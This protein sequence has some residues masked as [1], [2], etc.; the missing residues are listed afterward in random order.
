MTY[1]AESVLTI[2]Q[3]AKWLQCSTRMVERKGLRAIYLGPRTRRYLGST[4]LEYLKKLE[5]AA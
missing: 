5:Q 1:T 4:V 3:V 2:Q